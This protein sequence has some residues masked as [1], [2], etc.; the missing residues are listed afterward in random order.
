MDNKYI[1]YCG[2]DCSKCEARIATINDDDSLRMKVAKEWSI[3]NNVLIEK[4][5][6]NCL[7]CRLEGNKSIFCESICEIRK[8]AKNNVKTT[9]GACKNINTCEKL[10]QIT[11]NNKE[12]I[13]NL[14]SNNKIKI[15]TIFN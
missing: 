8:C 15:D 14:K 13:N 7:G 10:K 4:S 3:L 6:I 11:S 2:I 12:C 5:Q 1:A 9:C